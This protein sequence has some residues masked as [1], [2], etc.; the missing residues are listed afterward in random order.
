MIA[1][2]KKITHFSEGHLS[3]PLVVKRIGK[4]RLPPFMKA[5]YQVTKEKKDPRKIFNALIQ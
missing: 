4:K 1:K 3:L 5:I 2:G